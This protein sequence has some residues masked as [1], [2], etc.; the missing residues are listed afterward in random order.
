MHR[1]VFLSSTGKDLRA[2]RQAVIDHLAR[3]DHFLCDAQENF[4]ARDAGAIA[5]CRERVRRADIFVGLIGH[6]RG[7]EPP[8][9]NSGR[10]ITE[11]EYDWASEADKP[12]LVYVAPDD[13]TLPGPATDDP[14]AAERQ[15]R[16]RARLMDAHIVDQD[17]FA[18]PKDLAAA[19][20]QAL[21]NH[22]I[23]Q[24]LIAG[25]TGQPAPG[26]DPFRS[27][28]DAVA[29][30]AEDEHIDPA[31]LARRGVDVAEIEKALAE[32]A[33]A[34]EA[35]G[36]AANK[37][38]ARRYRQ[39]GALTFLHD[40]HKA[41]A[42][43]AKA[44]EL[45]PDDPE[46]WNWLG[47]L[48][49]RTGALDAAIDSFERVFSIGNTLAEKTWQAIAT[50]N[51][52]LIYFTRGELDR[53]EEMHLKSL[54][55][56]KEL[57]R[58]EGMAADYGNLGAIYLTR[59]ELDRAEAMYERAVKLAEELG[60]KEQQAAITGNLGV[61]YRTRGELDRAEEMHK[62]SLELNEELGRKEQQA[63][64]YGNLGLIYLT[65]GELDRAEAMYL[66]S[67]KIETE[68][69]R[70]EGIAQDNGNLGSLYQQRSDTVRACQH[71]ARARDLFREIGMA[72]QVEQTEALMRDAGCPDA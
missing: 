17:C 64:D 13:A 53:A 26:D 27:A 14:A 24:L 63:A 36:A 15:Q 70:K 46:G 38:A 25:Q 18:T 29:Q 2:Y 10:S 57:G 51:L 44:V 45:D 22:V 37:R 58:K 56:E 72:P 8:V 31:E 16:F 48:Q 12:R 21:A 60:N 40:T 6:Y 71:W 47:V 65:R 54:E 32:K 5:F 35:E 55:I 30:A 43:Y 4:G 42:A 61:I 9:D 23:G 33:A 19:V 52:G 50:G 69:G 66:K 68:L 1:V 28:A 49:L 67:L 39:I 20:G 34:D 7:W 41:M 59:G 3:L 62:R 11:M